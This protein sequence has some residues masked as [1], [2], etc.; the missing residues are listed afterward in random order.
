VVAA[1][2]L[3]AV[4]DETRVTAHERRAA[5]LGL[6]FFRISGA[7]G[8]GIPELLESMWRSLAPSRQTAA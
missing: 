1:N 3:D 4:D 7:T 6:P 5:E 8:L 2:K